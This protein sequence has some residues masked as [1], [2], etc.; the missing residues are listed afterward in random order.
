MVHVTQYQ[1]VGP[2]NFLVNYFGTASAELARRLY[3]RK[4][5]N[6]FDASSYEREAYDLESRFRAW[7]AAHP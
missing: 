3:E 4:P 1:E 7:H 6:P 2:A 5:L